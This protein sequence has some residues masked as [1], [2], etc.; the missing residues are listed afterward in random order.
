MQRWVWLLAILMLMSVMG[1]AT[2]S[3]AATTTTVTLTSY[4]YQVTIAD[5]DR[6]GHLD[7]VA[8]AIDTDVSENWQMVTVRGY[9]NGTFYPAQYK[10][11]LT[12]EQAHQL[13][14]MGVGLASGDANP[15]VFFIM[16]DPPFDKVYRL[17]GNG[18]GTFGSTS[19]WNVAEL[20]KSLQIFERNGDGIADVAYVTANRPSGTTL[21][22]RCG[23]GTGG[24][25]TESTMNA[26]SPSLLRVADVNGNGVA[27]YVM[28]QKGTANVSVVIGTSSCT[29]ATTK[30]DS[31]IGINTPPVS[32]AVGDVTGDSK[33]DIVVLSYNK[34][35]VSTG[36]GNGTFNTATA[37]MVASNTRALALADVDQDGDLDAV[38]TDQSVDGKVGYAV[39]YPNTGSGSWGTT[40]SYPV[41]GLPYDVKVADMNEDTIPDLIVVSADAGTVK[42]VLR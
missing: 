31:S 41:D 6:D 17:Y 35:W 1:V 23:N 30:T 21:G 36:N 8:V 32:M 18:D 24:L 34:L 19:G 42:V 20:P 40:T 16:Q 22:V 2:P 14:G 10:D 29:V 12:D 38:V 7:I 5:V 9:G 11:L 26:G 27:D 4:P 37:T 39:V 13:A 33:A 28:L 3:V 15:D 25:D